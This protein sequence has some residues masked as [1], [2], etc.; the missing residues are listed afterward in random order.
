[1]INFGEMSEDEARK[2]PDLMAIVEDKVKPE[3]TRI[4]SK[5]DFV[6][7]SPLPQRWWHYADKRPA[8]FR[9]IAQCDRVLVISRVSPHGARL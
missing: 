8:L 1:M 3:R 2:W 4:N 6:L 5:G 7:R 9:A